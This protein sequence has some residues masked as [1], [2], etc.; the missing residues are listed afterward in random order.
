LATLIDGARGSGNY[1]IYVTS[2]KFRRDY[3][4][5]PV[6]RFLD[7]DSEASHLKHIINIPRKTCSLFEYKTEL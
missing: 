5:L 3:R 4:V 2:E 1:Q 6:D 7:E